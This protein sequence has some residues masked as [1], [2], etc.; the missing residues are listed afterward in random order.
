MKRSLPLL[1]HFAWT[2]SSERH[3]RWSCIALFGIAVSGFSARADVMELRD[4]GVITGKVLNPD[5]GA[6]VKIETEDGTVV[7]I[8]RKLVKIRKSLDHNLDYAKKVAEQGDSVADHRA[9]IEHCDSRQLVTLA[10]AHRERLVEL[11]PNDRSALEHM[12]YFKDDT[13][14]KYM[15]REVVM[16][17]RGKIK[18]EKGQ[19]YTWEEKALLDMDQKVTMQRVAAEKEFTAR[20]NGLKSTA[21]QKLAE[22]QAYFASLNNP[23]LITKIAKSFRDPASGDRAF[24]LGLLKQ[25]PPRSVA[26]TLI[27]IAMEDRDINVV[28]E[29]V[30]FLAAGDEVVREM[31]VNAFAFHLKKPGTCDRAAYCMTPFNDKRFISAL[32]NSLVSFGLVRPAG[33]PGAMNA[34]VANNGG[35]AFANGAPPP[36]Q[37]VKQHKDVLAAL[38]SLTQENFGY[39]KQEWRRWF[40]RTYAYENLDL[41]R[42]EN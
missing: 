3:L 8:D 16:Q 26:P 36:Q 34:G 29:C 28:N 21:P 15:R 27:G 35:V 31:A 25:M 2:N 13:T 42:D 18:G 39:D 23:L 22:S 24:Y 30:D 32:I 11:D 6:I 7:E 20:L 33:P 41:R 12:R 14:G 5:K 38:Q 40:A 9:I 1:E 37:V 10:N 4:G 19:W 17:R